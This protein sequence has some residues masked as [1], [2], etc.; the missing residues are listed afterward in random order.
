MAGHRWHGIPS[1][2]LEAAVPL[3]LGS[4]PTTWYGEADG[5]AGRPAGR[6]WPQKRSL[7]LLLVLEKSL[8]RGKIMTE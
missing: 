7:A 1:I 8:S 3:P 4:S 6:S 2:A 5:R